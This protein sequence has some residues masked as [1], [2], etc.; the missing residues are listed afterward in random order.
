MF[1]YF[2]RDKRKADNLPAAYN[3]AAE[4]V[5]RARAEVPEEDEG[6]AVRAVFDQIGIS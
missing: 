3:Q 5:H 1:S 4:D 2:L 6:E